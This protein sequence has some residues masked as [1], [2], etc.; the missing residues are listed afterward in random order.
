MAARLDPVADSF[1]RL[2]ITTAHAGTLSSGASSAISPSPSATTSHKENPAAAL[3]PIATN[4]GVSKITKEFAAVDFD[5]TKQEVVHAVERLGEVIAGGL[6]GLGAA[7]EGRDLP[8][9]SDFW[10]KKGSA[11]VTSAFGKSIHENEP[12]TNGNTTTTGKNGVTPL[13]GL[14]SFSSPAAAWPANN[15]AP[16]AGVTTGASTTSTSKDGNTA[17][18][19]TDGS[20]ASAHTLPP[21]TGGPALYPTGTSAP[22]EIKIET[23][24]TNTSD[25]QAESAKAGA[26]APALNGN[27]TNVGSSTTGTTGTSGPAKAS[28]ASTATPSA[29]AHTSAAAPTAATAAAASTAESSHHHDKKQPSIIDDLKKGIK[30]DNHSATA[31]PIGTAPTG[32]ML[33]PAAVADHESHGLINNNKKDAST[34]GVASG[35]TAASSSATAP[36]VTPKK[37]AAATPGATSS[38]ATPATP[39]TEGYNTAPSTPSGTPDDR[40]RKSSM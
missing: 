13:G 17:S 10:A 8:V 29:T 37:T 7:H 33:G 5:H 9:V 3:D 6:S 26:H 36:P 34:L 18:K 30:N 22:K 21:V 27:N 4:A 15:G 35:T 23:P 32:G 25:I 1:S 38:A 11:S 31:A 28:T 40:K 16:S 24:K 20:S 12:T 39:K 19:A 2:V 14:A